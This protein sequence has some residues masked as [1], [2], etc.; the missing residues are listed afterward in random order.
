[1]CVSRT[2]SYCHCTHILFLH[3][4]VAQ[5]KKAE[6]LLRSRLEIAPSPRLWC[7]LGSVTLS[8]EPYETAWE[9]SGHTYARAKLALGVR[10]FE[11]KDMPAAI[12]ELTAGLALAPHNASEWFL[13][14]VICLRLERWDAGTEAFSRVVQVS[15]DVPVQS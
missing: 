2:S 12:R 7:I 8:D 11:R 9:L 3:F 10:A 6:A 13:L 5:T 14:G 15:I 1:M 4:F